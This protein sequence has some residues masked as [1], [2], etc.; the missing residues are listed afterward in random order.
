MDSERIGLAV[1]R[2]MHVTAHEDVHIVVRVSM[3]WDNAHKNDR[4]QG[5]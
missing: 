4:S 5:A 3:G 2:G 1:H